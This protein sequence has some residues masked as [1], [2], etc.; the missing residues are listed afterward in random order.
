VHPSSDVTAM[1]GYSM[2]QSSSAISSGDTLNQAVG[3]LEK[4]ISD[5][6][7]SN[8][9]H[10]TGDENVDGV[11]TF[12]D[13]F[14]GLGGIETDNSGFYTKTD[15]F[16]D[17]DSVIE[18]TYQSLIAAKDA[19]NNYMMD[20]YYGR[21]AD[22][23]TLLAFRLR[24]KDRTKAG[25]MQ[26]M[27]WPSTDLFTL[28][29]PTTDETANGNA[30]ANTYWVR[31]YASGTYL[32]LAGGTLT[33]NVRFKRSNI[34]RGTAPSSDS[35][36]ELAD[37]VDSANNRISL[38]ESNYYTDMSSKVAL[39]AYK[40]TVA[41]GANIGSLGIGCTSAGNVYTFCPTPASSDNSTQIATTAWVANADCV[42]HKT[43]NET[44][45]G[46]KTFNSRISGFIGYKLNVS[47][48]SNPSSNQYAN[49]VAIFDADGDYISELFFGRE[50]GGGSG[51][52]IRTYRRDRQQTTSWTVYHP[53]SSTRG[54]CFG[55]L[56]K[57]I[58]L[59]A[60]AYTRG[61]TPS[62]TVWWS[63]SCQG[64]T[65]ADSGGVWK[66]VNTDNQS[67]IEFRCTQNKAD[68]PTTKSLWLF[69][70]GDATSACGTNA[71]IFRPSNAVYS[72]LGGTGGY[73]WGQIYSTSSTISTSDERQKCEISSIPDEILD[74]WETCEFY[75]YKMIDSVNKKGNSARYHTGM[76]AQRLKAKFND[77]EE[78]LDKYGL[79]CYDEWD[80]VAAKK[81][82]NGNITEPA[83]DAGNEYSIRYE[84]ALCMEA[85]YQR[86]ENARLKAR[87]AS[88]EDRL[89][90]LELRLGSE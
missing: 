61:T 88:L 40:T 62:S 34:T 35:I 81:D 78:Y 10:R 67:H 86:R 4:A 42:V 60:V 6:D 85:A 55:N 82:E 23:V 59:V 84:E 83:M 87:I 16:N 89:A 41:S 63:I 9:V 65:S 50:S 13:L 5:A 74:A 80:A 19:N 14:K 46:T 3:K 57:D 52:V 11:K 70:N 28:E 66:Y 45:S 38:I 30:A 39:F 72:T 27:Y 68:S 51:T 15:L 32:P 1:T 18:P 36:L 56:Y 29:I 47:K 64:D 17:T 20:V 58:G 33:G 76:I 21:H 37:C 75:Q 8:V 48:T 73:R 77:A 24:N 7:V 26:F 43:G 25:Y 71:S 53:Q 54:Y 12:N 31:R 79:F 44:I 90:A 49:P 22:D 2:P 69:V